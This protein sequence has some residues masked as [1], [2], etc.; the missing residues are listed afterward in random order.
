MHFSFWSYLLGLIVGMFVIIL[1]QDKGWSIGSFI[2]NHPTRKSQIS[3]W[4]GNYEKWIGNVDYYV[5]MDCISSPGEKIARDPRVAAAWNYTNRRIDELKTAQQV[6]KQKHCDEMTARAE[7]LFARQTSEIFS[8]ASLTEE[9]VDVFGSL[10]GGSFMPAQSWALDE[11]VRS[12][13]ARRSAQIAAD[14]AAWL[15]AQARQ[16]SAEHFRLFRYFSRNGYAKIVGIGKIE[17]P[18]DYN[19]LLVR[20]TLQPAHRDFRP[21]PSEAG[22]YHDD[23]V[24]A[25]SS[26]D[27]V[28]ATYLLA[29]C[30]D[31]LDGDE[32]RAE[33]GEPL[34][35]QLERFVVEQYK[36]RT[37]PTI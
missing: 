32:V 35:A 11:V 8:D 6:A 1:V 37:R 16:G 13:Y 12:V 22:Q 34:Y 5:L 31:W 33:I 26:S 15:L 10:R 18:A 4:L 30:N 2:K 23:T 14:G 20:Y 9:F 25:I 36:G 29:L 3:A 21:I 27:I 24:T 7:A 17:Y 28:L 19:R